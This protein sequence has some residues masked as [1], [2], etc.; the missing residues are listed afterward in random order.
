[1]AAPEQVDRIIL[2]HMHPDHIGG[3]IDKAGARV[4][5]NA[6]MHANEADWFFWRDPQMKAKAGAANASFFDIAKSSS[7]AYEDRAELYKFG[8]DL[9]DGITALDMS[10]HT[11]GHSGSVIESNG[12]SLF[13]LGDVVHSAPLQFAHPEWGIAFDVDQ[14][15]AIKAR[16]LK[17]EELVQEYSRGE[18]EAVTLVDEHLSDAGVTVDTLMARGLVE[19]LDDIERI[20][21][22]TSIAENRRNASLREIE[23]RR[24][25]LGEALRRVVP[26]IE[27]GEFKEIQTPSAKGKNA[28]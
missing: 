7:D 11:P 16:M 13:I 24:A 27:D 9:G 21:C 6:T 12:S 17:A 19:K 23:R 26:E 3:V 2:A 1:L 18:P 28:A 15:A 14:E 10:G 22:L 20:D 5:P 25:V 4:F 8:R